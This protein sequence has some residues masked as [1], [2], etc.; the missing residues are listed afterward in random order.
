MEKVLFMLSNMNVGGTEKALLNMLAFMPKEEYDVTVLLLE[1]KG[2]FLK[3]LPTWV[4]VEELT[5]F[6]EMKPLIMEAPKNIIKKFLKE[7]K[8]MKAI[9]IGIYHCEFKISGDRSSYYR[10]VQKSCVWK[11]KYDVAVAYAGP[12]DFISIFILDKIQA[13]KKIQWIHFDVSKFYPNH[14]C[15]QNNYFKF[16]KII[17]VST[18][19]A[20]ELVK[21]IPE[22]KEKVEVIPNLISGEIC[23]KN[24]QEFEAY[25]QKA[26]K[27]IL[28]VGRLTAE[29]GQEMIPD[30][31]RILIDKGYQNFKWYIVGDGNERKNIEKKIVEQNIEKYIE[32]IGITENPYP[33][34]KGADIYV[35]TSL[36]EGFCI[37]LAEAKLFHL[38]IVTTDVAGAYEQ[39]L[40]KKDGYI[41][42]RDVNKMADKIMELLM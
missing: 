26:E 37:T 41:V 36:H 3:Y 31:V 28:T 33:Y 24:A 11:D 21:I 2:G 5:E 38:P 19:A 27:I 13:D 32:M 7:K 16:D 15:A 12:M 42:K 8:V 23:Y 17:P 14:K 20:D 39:I 29:K 10:F 18:K 4:K 1:K 9:K 22:I 35:Q 34:Y 6:S 30:I 40:S 25:P